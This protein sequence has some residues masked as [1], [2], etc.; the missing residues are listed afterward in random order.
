MSALC[1]A[2]T[3]KL[4]EAT[5]F[6]A[7]LSLVLEQTEQSCQNATKAFGAQMCFAKKFSVFTVKVQ[8]LVQESLA[9]KQ[10]LRDR[11]PD[12]LSLAEVG[13]SR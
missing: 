9:L 6:N 11:T 13:T 2:L 1:Q 3:T 5:E 12:A 8:A 4:R 7:E 10:L